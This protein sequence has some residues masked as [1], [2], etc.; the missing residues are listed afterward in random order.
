MTRST[1]TGIQA[2]LAVIAAVAV[3]V[4]VVPPPGLTRSLHAATT[5]PAS[6]AGVKDGGL[7]GVH[8]SGGG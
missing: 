7:T 1:V 8:P 4:T 2:A 6:G 5:G 3:L